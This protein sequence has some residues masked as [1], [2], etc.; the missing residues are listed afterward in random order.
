ML[1]RTLLS[2]FT[3]SQTSGHINLQKNRILI[4]CA[5]IKRMEMFDKF[6]TVNGRRK[7]LIVNGTAFH[8]N[9]QRIAPHINHYQL[10]N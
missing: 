5:H 6:I 3:N 4:K 9:V 2:T 1:S 8:N 10:S 7:F